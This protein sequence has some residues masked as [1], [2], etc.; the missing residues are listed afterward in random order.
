MSTLITELPSKLP[1]RVFNED[2]EIKNLLKDID[3]EV[4]NENQMQMQSNDNTNDALFELE[5]QLKQKEQELRELQES[6][7]FDKNNKSSDNVEEYTEEE[8]AIHNINNSI[9]IP[10]FLTKIKTSLYIVFLFFILYIIPL[11]KVIYKYISLYKIPYSDVIIKSILAGI[12][13]F[14]ISNL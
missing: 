10:A 5:L 3:N 14:V 8:N 1:T 4:S 7:N 12:I 6:R 2:D 13:Y 11:E 9:S